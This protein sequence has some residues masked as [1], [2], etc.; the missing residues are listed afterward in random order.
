MH[1]GY[2]LAALGFLAAGAGGL[3]PAQVPYAVGVHVWAIGGVGMMTLAMMTRA[4]LGHTGRALIASPGT[5]LAYLCLILAL[6]ARVGMAF[7]PDFAVLL[8]HVSALA[9]IAGFAAYL[10]VYEPMLAGRSPRG[11]APQRA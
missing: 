1:V 11:K 3:W 6:L 8:M 5:C 2:G 10:V 7:A 9:W 4:T